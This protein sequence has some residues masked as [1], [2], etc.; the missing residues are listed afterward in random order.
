MSLP[1][2]K[3]HTELL[4]DARLG[5]LPESTQLRYLQLLMLAGECGAE[6]QA[7]GSLQQNGRP[8]AQEDLAWRLRVPT[9]SLKTDLQALVSAGL[10]RITGGCY[11]LEDFALRQGRPHDEQRQS[12]SSQKRHQRGSEELSS[13]EGEMSAEDISDVREMNSEDSSDV[14]EESSEDISDV[15]EMSSADSQNVLSIDIDSE[16]EIDSEKETGREVDS[17]THSAAEAAEA[18]ESENE[19][20]SPAQEHFA[21]VYQRQPVP[22]QCEK[23][24]ELEAAYGSERLKSCINWAASRHIP[25][26]RALRA[27]HTAIR[28]WRDPPARASPGQSRPRQEPGRARV[29]AIDAMLSE[30]SRPPGSE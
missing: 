13:P 10:L 30:L 21:R 9:E 8:L 11:L 5:R 17:H 23:I 7:I 12:W 15:R 28:F 3:L 4:D 26:G 20:V 19:C 6:G 1:W 16:P 27:I 24:A 14:R 25:P 18:P 2:I 22:L 29:S